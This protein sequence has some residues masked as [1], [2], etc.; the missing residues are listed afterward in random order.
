MK[1]IFISDDLQVR[2]EGGRPRW[3]RPG[4]SLKQAIEMVGFWLRTHENAVA[5]IWL[6]MAGDELDLQR[7]TAEILK[8]DQAVEAAVEALDR[9]I[10]G[11][12][13]EPTSASAARALAISVREEERGTQRKFIQGEEAFVLR[14]YDG[15]LAH[16]GP[17]ADRGH[18]SACFYMG[19]LYSEAAGVPQDYVKAYMWFHL[20]AE[21]GSQHP[22]NEAKRR[23]AKLMSAEELK[24]ARKITS[25][26]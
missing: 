3:S 18:P 10:G 13:S 23:I 15:A 1:W 21:F 16:L 5:D 22:A 26:D 4:V 6:E 9:L 24:E 2:L 11:E 25:S 17:L 8:R 12:P 7:R 20:A 14:D 19:R